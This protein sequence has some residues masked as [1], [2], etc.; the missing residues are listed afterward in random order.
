[1]QGAG[2]KKNTGWMKGVE[3]EEECSLKCRGE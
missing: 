1:M 2:G 3:G